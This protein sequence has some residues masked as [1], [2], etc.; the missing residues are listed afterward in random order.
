[1]NNAVGVRAAAAEHLRI[2]RLLE[3]HGD[4]IGAVLAYREVI[5]EGVEP[6]AAE[7]RRRVHQLASRAWPDRPA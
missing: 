5:Q 1:M 3:A 6:E 2:G 4:A 7:A